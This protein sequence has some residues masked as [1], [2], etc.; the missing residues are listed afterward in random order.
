MVG[1]VVS[2][3]GEVGT[4]PGGRRARAGKEIVQDRPREKG[5]SVRRELIGTKER[6]LETVGIRHQHSVLVAAATRVLAAVFADVPRSS[7]CC[8]NT[9]SKEFL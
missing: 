9:K 3:V 5:H 2:Q 8:S 7:S 6:A 1:L 4:V